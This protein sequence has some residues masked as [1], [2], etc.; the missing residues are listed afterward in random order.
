MSR[1]TVEIV[2]Q[3]I[4]A[5]A[6]GDA[7]WAL[8]FVDPEV[9]VDLTG[10]GVEGGMWHG[11]VGLA[12]AVRSYRGAFNEYRFEIRGLIDAGDCVVGQIREAG[13][14]RTSGVEAEHLVGL[15]YSIERG[16]IIRLTEYRSYD[17]ALEAVGLRE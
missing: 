6:A 7:E 10:M 12:R 1:E 3:H 9:V 4:E 13:R 17:E 11:H 15:V 5:Y 8:S 16:R 2:R 14:G